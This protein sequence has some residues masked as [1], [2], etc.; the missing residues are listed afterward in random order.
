MTQT[1]PAVILASTSPARS[2]ILTNALVPFTVS[3]SAVD[4]EGELSQLI[5]KSGKP[6]SAE[7]AVFLAGLKAEAVARDA[8][9]AIVIGCDSVFEVDGVSYGKPYTVEETV[10][11][12][13]IMSGKT[14]TLHTGQVVIDTTNGNLRSSRVVSTEVTFTEVS[15]EEARAYA[16]TGEPL[17]CA[18]AFTLDGRG[19]A[20]VAGIQGDANAVVGISTAALRE[21]FAELGHMLPLA[22]L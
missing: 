1:A 8:A 12:W 14:G 7:E 16:E 17:Q 19:S 13:S 20:F 2:R 10:N 22:T 6:S 15:P 21:Q 9:G 5:A 18:G 4:E 11:R 3:P